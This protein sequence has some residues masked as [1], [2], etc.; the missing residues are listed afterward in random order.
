MWEA[1]VVQVSLLSEDEADKERYNQGGSR[2]EMVLL[3][4]SILLLTLLFIS[5]TGVNLVKFP[6]I[7]KVELIKVNCLRF[8]LTSSKE[9]PY[10]GF[11]LSHG[12]EILH[13]V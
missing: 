1:V 8:S 11:F 5:K 10:I 4:K 7:S 3:K 6:F 9:I 13:T 2:E 12:Q